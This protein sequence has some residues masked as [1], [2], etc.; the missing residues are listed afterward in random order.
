MAI[1]TAIAFG[2]SGE[3]TPWCI[4]CSG[5]PHHPLFAARREL[6][7]LF[8]LADDWD[9]ALSRLEVVGI[10][11]AGTMQEGPHNGDEALQTLSKTLQRFNLD[12]AHCYSPNDEAQIKAAIEAGPGG[13]PAFET[14]I[15]RIGRGLCAPAGAHLSR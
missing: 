6:Y 2:A 3:E 5:L 1:R 15:R 7:T 12:E 4:T 8:A 11:N 10:A 9:K 13:R 14:L